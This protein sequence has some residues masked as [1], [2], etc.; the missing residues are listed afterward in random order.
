M[1]TKQAKPLYEAAEENGSVAVWPIDSLDLAQTLDCGQ[2]FRWVPNGDGSWSG[3]AH[4]RLL[5]VSLG[6]GKFI[7]HDCCLAEYK[8]IWEQ[9]FDLD[10]DYAALKRRFSADPVMAKAVQYA[11]GIR[12][13]KQEP[14]ETLCSFIISQ[15]NNIKRIK[16]I[17]SRLCEQFGEPARGGGYSFPTPERLAALSPGGLAQIRCG[18]REK[19]ILDAAK[20]VASGEIDLDALSHMPMDKARDELMKI[21]GVGPKVAACALLYG[22]GF[23]DAFPVDVWIKRAL[24]VL[25]GG[26]LP[27]MLLKE[28][29]IAQQYLFYYVREEKIKI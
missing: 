18:F 6:A 1:I 16:G 19:Y 4:G 15:N 28:A 10:R 5:T 26:S 2:A 13:L 14:W 29:G 21:K 9:Y 25:Y 22:L 8:E 11:G 24:E 3:V 23:K 12:V 20:K 27:E 17:I 7:L